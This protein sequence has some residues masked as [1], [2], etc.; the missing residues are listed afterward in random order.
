MGPK[1]IK[2]RLEIWTLSAVLI[3][4][5]GCQQSANNG[6]TELASNC[7]QTKTIDP[8]TLGIDGAAGAVPGKSVSY[9]LNQDVN[10]ASVQRVSWKADGKDMGGPQ[11]TSIMSTYEKAGEFVV[12]AEV[13]TAESTTQVAY[14]TVVTD[15]LA[16]NGPALGMAEQMASFTLVLPVGVT[17]TSAQWSFGDNT[18]DVSGLSPQ[19]H[20]YMVAGT[21]TVSVNVQLASGDNSIVM[22]TIQVIPPTDGMECVVDL[23]ISGPTQVTVNT[24]AAMSIYVP[25]CLSWQ[26]RIV[27]W[28]FGDATTIATG[29]N[30]QHT[31]TR[32]GTFNLTVGLYSSAT[33]AAILT[34][35][36]QITVVDPTAPP[37][38]PDP[39]ACTTVGEQ[40]SKEGS[41]F[42]EIVTC[43]VGGQ[44]TDTFKNV[45]VEAC[46]LESGVKRWTEV[47]TTKTLVNQGTCEGESCELP[48][49]AMSGMDVI[50]MDLQ[51][52]NGKYYLMSGTSKTFYSSLLPDGTCS[53][54]SQVR[55]CSNGVLSGDSAFTF[56]SCQNGC[57][58]FGTH[59]TSKTDVVTGEVSVQKTCSF[60]ETGFF[61]IFN[62]VSDQICQNGVIVTS[63]THQGSIKSAG[64]CPTYSWA[65]TDTYTSCSAD[66]GGEQS[67]LYECRS[68][69]G[70]VVSAD[71]CSGAAPVVIRLCDGNPDAV[72]RS[73]VSVVTED[74]G[75]SVRCPANQIG[76]K[77]SKRDVT[78]TLNYACIEHQVAQESE[79]VTYGPWVTEEYCRDY[80]P[81]RCSQDSLGKKDSVG[82]FAWM[83]KCKERVPV[84]KEFLENFATYQ[85]A[86]IRGDALLLNGHEIY[87]TFMDRAYKPERP[88]IAPVMA[89]YGCNVPASVYIAA[90][91]VASCST[92]EQLIMA[93]AEANDKLAYVPF[94]EAWQKNMKFVATLQSQSNMSSKDVTKTQVEN[95][96][97]EVEDTDHEILEFQMKS[98]GHL[99]VTPNH[100]LVT[101]EGT[102]R[103]A[104]DFK[105]GENLI[106]LG[107]GRDSISSIT[108]VSY[109]G[110][111]YNLFV[112]SS[113]LHKNIVITNG[114]LNGTAYFQNDGAQHLNKRLFRGAL[115]RG[116]LER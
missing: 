13:V 19:T 18:P 95:W 70:G 84:I 97:T 73:E 5:F 109:Y 35:T 69:E 43:G 82:R 93:Q 98:G 104:S 92:P 96:I 68:S 20:T 110:K 9:S 94:I 63:N 26:V 78:T 27:R 42:T 4:S 47:S 8:Q 90:V 21:Y 14:K 80:V 83:M 64:L 101:D 72:R 10:C 79:T 22:H 67:L 41:T 3:A 36:R 6:S 11:S 46:T 31:Y 1:N 15:G 25:P 37:P 71:R 74:A 111:V 45:T 86:T 102:M 33:G 12:S 53:D 2:M 40:R 114:Y 38:P 112:K 99:R 50:A 77:V 29:F 103:L 51:L 62:Q 32:T 116:V 57:A 54:I 81:H 100:P 89:S 75:S 49:G 66:C 85:G 91:C 115:I 87:P 44:R 55:T 107:G 59:G 106:R 88:W 24:A 34:L 16:I 58:G 23:A 65:S 30:I 60:G 28:N 17:A 108:K 105:V 52:I 76:V 61:D 113:E 56:L 39:N 7:V 48:E